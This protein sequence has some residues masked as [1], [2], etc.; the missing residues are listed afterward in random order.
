MLLALTPNPA[1]DR[2]LVVPGFRH[3]DV[4]RSAERRDAAG[5][6][7]LNV[8]R[9]ARMLGTAVRAL[10]PLAGYNG[11]LIAELAEADRLD[12]RWAWL[13]TGESRICLLITDLDTRDTLVINEHGPALQPEGWLALEQLIRSE[14]R[15]ATALAS[16]GSLLPG[17]P[18]AE[19]LALLASLAPELMVLLDC[20]G[21][22]LRG[23]LDLPLALLKINQHELGDALGHPISNAAEAAAA[24]RLVCRR[25]P[26]AA[27][28]TLG[29]H[30][31]VA[32]NAGGAWAARTPP[33]DAIS[34]VGSG[35]A[36]M[37]GAASALLGGA[38]LAEA[39]RLGV[40]CGGA[41][42]LTLGAGA[43]RPDDLARLLPSTELE[44][45][46]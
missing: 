6:K 33:L 38:D 44:R 1:I 39:L 46:A 27:I 12:T 17:A 40:A 4:T 7:G 31:A 45:L 18:V 24:A 30:G 41:N 14:A 42:A 25:G 10:G 37:A 19:F 3:S 2:T 29:K 22:V 23:A 32:A 28:V 11:R 36:V 21:V 34:P 26:R 8:A 9:V 16:S 5:G 13:P 35:D 15:T 43:V 20:S